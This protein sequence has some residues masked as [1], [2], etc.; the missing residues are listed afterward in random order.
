MIAALT[1]ELRHVD[2]RHLHLLC[3]A[4]LYELLFPASDMPALQ[5]AV[6]QELTL[7]TI[8][9]LGGDP[10]RGGLEPTLIGFLRARDKNFFEIFTTVKG[11]GPKKALR[12]L[13]V[14]VGEIAGAIEGRDAKFLIGLPEIGKRTAETIIAELAGKL[15]TFAAEALVAGHPARPAARRNTA[16]EDA[17]AGLMGLGERRSDAENLLERARALNPELKSTDQLLREMLRLRSTRG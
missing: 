13:A 4:V 2:E 11:I 16:E 17:I 10:S 8:F 5:A 12:A 6:G 3:G 15:K 1:G 9:Y 14:S 7:H